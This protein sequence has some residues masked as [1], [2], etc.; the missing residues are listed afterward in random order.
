MP[1]TQPEHS[2]ASVGD[3]API[4]LMD[5][6]SV[7]AVDGQRI[8]LGVVELAPGL[9]MPEHRHTNEQVGVVIRGEMTFTVGGETRPRRPGDMWVIPPD[10]PHSVES[11]GTAGCTLVES[12]SPPRADWVEKSRGQPVAGPWPPG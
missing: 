5:G 11:T 7:R 8:T 1:S 6:I 9:R 10:V 4:A 2:F 12:F 3:L